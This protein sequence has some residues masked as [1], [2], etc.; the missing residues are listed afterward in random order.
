M[1]TSPV[2]FADIAAS[3]L[4]VPP[5]ARNADLTLNQAENRKLIRH[6]EAGGVSTLM[7]GGNANFYNLP[8]SEYR[9]TLEFLAEA[10]GAASWVIPSLGP[11]YGRMIDQADILRGIAFPTAMVLPQTFPFTAAGLDT[12]IRRCAE[13]MGRKL[14]VY[15]K[16]DN[17]MPPA[18]LEKLVKDGLVAAVKYAVVRKEPRDDAYLAEIVKRVDRRYIVSGIGERPAIAHLRDFGLSAFTS[19]SVCVAPRMS[20]ALL[21]CLQARDYAGA[22]AIRRKYLPLEDLRDSLGAI[23]VLHDAVTLAGIADM[24]PMLP[25]LSNLEPA[26]R[27]GVAEAARLLLSED[28]QAKAA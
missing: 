24:G 19:G 27:P 22:E 10:A 12:G 18:A 5:L 11:D 13:R 2:E 4:A 21:R 16:A 14:I 9:A 15:I 28:L 20:A 3:V 17:Y 23:R 6:L 26:Q 7:Y 25:L 1:K 8:L